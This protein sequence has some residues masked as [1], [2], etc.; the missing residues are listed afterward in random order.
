MRYALV[1][2]ATLESAK[3]ME[4]ITVTGSMLEVVGDILAM[5]NLIQAILFCDE[6]L[7]LDP[8]GTLKQKS[9]RLFAPFRQVIPDAET[10]HQLLKQGNHMTDNYLPCIE[11]GVF[12]DDIFSAFF[13]ALD[14]DLRFVWEKKSDTFY[15]TPRVIPSGEYKNSLIHRKQLGMILQELSDKT[16]LIDVNPRPPLLYDSEG[17]IINNCYRVQDR[18]GKLYPTKFSPQSE[19]LFKAANYMAYRSNLHLIAARELKADLVVSPMR[20]MFQWAGYHHFCLKTKGDIPQLSDTIYGTG[21]GGSN[22]SVLLRN[23]PMFTFWIAE[24][25]WMTEDAG[26]ISAAYELRDKEEFS[27]MRRCLAELGERAEN[28]AD[29]ELSVRIRER[30]NRQLTGI[31]EKYCVNPNKGFT[32][33]SFVR[34][35]I[36]PSKAKLPG[37]P[38]F[39]FRLKP[40]WPDFDPGRDS[41]QHFGVIY[42]SV[43]D[44]LLRIDEMMEYYNSVASKINYKTDALLQ[45]FKVQ[46]NGP[47]EDS[48]LKVKPM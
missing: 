19:A 43:H 29:P 44:D 6:I 20:A 10:Y 8:E 38:D 37:I 7:Y 2:E 22:P 21:A 25:M 36:A 9:S 17:Q 33:V 12:T 30:L 23:I 1:D 4:G 48:S 26:F 15:L 40:D 31:A 28:N 32:S 14:M 16:F 3:R 5:E 18:D 41:R 13:K 47:S 42:R 27:T 24:N 34:T 45:N 11:G 35:S 39:S 46:M